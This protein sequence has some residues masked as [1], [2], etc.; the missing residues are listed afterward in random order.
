MSEPH[1][2]ELASCLSEFVGGSSA[3]LR[4]DRA[5]FALP[6]EQGGM[7]LTQ[8]QELVASLQAKIISR[9]FEL[10]RLV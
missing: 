2:R 3:T 7:R 8:V 9:L 1:A 5:A 10:E 4:P 6:W